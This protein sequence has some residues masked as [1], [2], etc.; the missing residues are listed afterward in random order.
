MTAYFL[1]GNH[2][3]TTSHYVIN[4]VAC[5]SKSRFEPLIVYVNTLKP[6]QNGRHFPD[7]IFK[8]I[9]LKID[10][11]ISVKISLKFVTTGPINN[12]PLLVQII[13]CRRSWQA[14]I[15]TNDGWITDAYMRPSSSMI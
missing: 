8:C 12:I 7:D 14:I 10:L 11:W 13:A 5:R 4:I 1:F 9:F 6:R 2:K 15:W 3:C